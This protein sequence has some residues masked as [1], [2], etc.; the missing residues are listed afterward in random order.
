MFLSLF[1]KLSET[2]VS[3]Y[4]REQAQHPAELIKTG[5]PNFLCSALPVHWRSNKTLP[6][7]F[8]VSFCHKTCYKKPK[9]R[10][11]RH[12]WLHFVT[13]RTA[14]WWPWTR[15][16][17]TTTAPSCATTPPWW[18]TVSPS[19]MISG[20]SAGQEEVIISFNFLVRVSFLSQVRVSTWPSQCTQAL[21]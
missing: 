13:S 19:S 7:G 17:T 20:S 18:G 16:T 15:A 4:F 6:V 21:W 2:Y 12:R 8:K 3:P 11:T 5:S 10:I 14:P 1:L 9:L